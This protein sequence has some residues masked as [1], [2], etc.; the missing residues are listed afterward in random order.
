MPPTPPPTPSI[1]QTAAKAQLG[2]QVAQVA[3]VASLLCGILSLL[4]IGLILAGLFPSTWSFVP[5]FACGAIGVMFGHLARRVT[6]RSSAAGPATA[7]LV[8]S[9]GGALLSI[10][11]VVAIAWALDSAGP[12]PLAISPMGIWQRACAQ[13]IY[14]GASCPVGALSI[15]G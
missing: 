13:A 4:L 8:L 15:S 3:A 5:S 12:F 10:A 14:T 7:G 11:L 6:R 2:A 1:P 9:Y